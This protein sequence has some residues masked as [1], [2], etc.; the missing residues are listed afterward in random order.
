MR[1]PEAKPEVRQ[2]VLLISSDALLCAATRR[3]ME[4]RRPEVCMSA[5]NNVAAA[6]RVLEDSALSVILLAEELSLAPRESEAPR[7]DTV[8]NALAVYAPVVVIGNA[9]C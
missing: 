8:V 3:E 2:T 7:L 6:M 1:A 4:A 9:E 5:I